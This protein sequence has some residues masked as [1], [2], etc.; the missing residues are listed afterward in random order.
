MT[1]QQLLQQQFE[2]I[3]STAG[4]NLD[5]M[6][7]DHSLVQPEPSGNCANWVLAHLV[8]VQNGVMRVVGAPPVWQHDKLPPT[9]LP[10]ID[11]EEQALDWEAMK[12]A[13]LSSRERCIAGLGEL[14]DEKLNEQ[15]PDPFGGKS[16]RGELLG[17][18]ANH[19]PYHIGQLGL[20]RR[21]AGLRGAISGPGE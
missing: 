21:L 12:G 15:I 17:I 10:P 6:N 3:Y 13:L 11:S 9:S 19:Q 5:G 14:T 16:T 4:A 2:L 1:T 18:L 7:R 20:L 8:Q